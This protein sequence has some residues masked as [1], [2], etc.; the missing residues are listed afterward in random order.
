MPKA[1]GP[2][3]PV[4]SPTSIA[5]LMLPAPATPSPTKAQT[6]DT[7]EAPPTDGADTTPAPTFE[8][9]VSFN[10]RPPS[11]GRCATK[12]QAAWRGWYERTRDILEVKWFERE[13]GY[14][15]PTMSRLALFHRW[16]ILP[17]RKNSA[18]SSN[19]DDR[20]YGELYSEPQHHLDGNLGHPLYHSCSELNEHF[21]NVHGRP[22]TQADFDAAIDADIQDFQEGLACRARAL[23][24]CF[25]AQS[26][27]RYRT[28]DMAMRVAKHASDYGC[29]QEFGATDAPYFPRKT[30]QSIRDQRARDAEDAAWDAAA[31]ER[32][33][34]ADDALTARWLQRPEAVVAARDAENA[35]TA[36]WIRDKRARDNNIN[37]DDDND[38]DS[39][40]DNDNDNTTNEMSGPQL[41]EP[42]APTRDAG[43]G[44]L[45]EELDSTP[46]TIKHTRHIAND[47]L[48]LYQKPGR[49]A[50]RD[51]T[52]DQHHANPAHSGDGNNDDDD[53]I[54]HDG[55]SHGDGGSGTSAGY[56]NTHEKDDN[57]NDDNDDNNTEPEGDAP[58]P[59][60]GATPRKKVN[61]KLNKQKLKRARAARAK[62]ERAAEAAAAT[63]TAESRELAEAKALI[64]RDRPER[65][66]LLRAERARYDALRAQATADVERRIRAAAT[67]DGCSGPKD[68]GSDGR[69]AATGDG[70]SGPNDEDRD[71][72]HGD[73][74]ND[75]DGCDSD[76]YGPGEGYYPDGGYGYAEG[77]ADVDAWE[78]A[79]ELSHS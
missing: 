35:L 45:T 77:L 25:T 55:G 67:G 31:D 53:G 58:P 36:R 56:D 18:N 13:R 78:H 39:D 52:T 49:L 27:S 59:R 74:D 9:E 43:R 76:G 14:L 48:L 64:E 46:L 28:P 68:G 7:S 75:G 21:L 10:P 73:N 47:P 65:E 19:R 66:A 42:Q 1:R 72:N 69:A 44:L 41:R 2:A 60:A 37:N 40:N 54:H 3:K 70:C 57:D 17:H 29:D 20:R 50:V 6:P 24:A 62:K 30:P 26:E 38:N 12:L 22:A 5:D 71:D 23:H 51:H 15:H 8:S 61:M 63:A 34:A 32:R 33:A 4:A 16:H 11:E 79:A